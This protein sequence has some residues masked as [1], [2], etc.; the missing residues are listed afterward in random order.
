MAKFRCRRVLLSWAQMMGDIVKV[1][2]KD[3]PK[4][5]IKPG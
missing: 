5:G 1:G 4:Q 2:E 3:D